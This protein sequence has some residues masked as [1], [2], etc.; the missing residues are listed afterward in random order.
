MK[1]RIETK[2]DRRLVV[3]LA[4]AIVISVGLLFLPIEQGQ[5]ALAAPCC[6]SCLPIYNSCT[7]QCEDDCG[8]DLTCQSACMQTCSNNFSFCIGHC[9][10]CSP[11][12]PPNPDCCYQFPGYWCPIECSYCYICF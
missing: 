6:Q 11:P 9:S 7:V 3:L 2:F 1:S 8:G 4:A 10:Y 5:E 12:P